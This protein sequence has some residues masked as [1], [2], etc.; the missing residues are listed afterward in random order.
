M[1]G[2]VT[3]HGKLPWFFTASQALAGHVRR[4]NGVSKDDTASVRSVVD[5]WDYEDRLPSKAS[6]QP[7][8]LDRVVVQGVPMDPSREKVLRRM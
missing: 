5:G 6:N 2:L 7:M 4:G 3:P 8:E 1:L